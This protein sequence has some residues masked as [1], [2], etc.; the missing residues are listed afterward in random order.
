MNI[1]GFFT[2]HFYEVPTV[3]KHSK[4]HFNFL[5]NDITNPKYFGFLTEL[6]VFIAEVN[7][8]F[9]KIKNFFR[10]LCFDVYFRLM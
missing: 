8:F 4:L 9:Y 7:H 1:C 10:F 6:G 3:V 2:E 5:N